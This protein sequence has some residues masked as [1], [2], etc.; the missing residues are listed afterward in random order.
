VAVITANEALLIE[1]LSTV[2]S[3]SM[4]IATPVVT[5][6]GEQPAILPSILL[7]THTGGF[8]QPASV[9][10]ETAIPEFR[11]HWQ[12]ADVRFKNVLI[13]YLGNNQKVYHEVNNLLKADQPNLV[14]LDPAFA[15]HGK[16]YTGMTAVVVE[17]YLQLCKHVQVFLPNFTEACLILNRKVPEHVTKSELAIILAELSKKTGLSKVAITGIERDNQIG[18]VFMSDQQ[19]KYVS[20]QKVSGDYF[21]TGDLFSSLVFEFLLNQESF[22]TALTLANQW[23][24]EAVADTIKQISR[25][26]RMGVRLQ[27]VFS[28]I[29]A[30]KGS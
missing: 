19:V 24:S 21:G 20:S 11:H 13:G 12:T 16:L 28:K 4:S 6:F 29:L 25:D 5:V 1:D 22:E 7:S 27:T 8:G 17:N 23:T 14:V 3:V 18:T 26:P 9:S 2:G 15:D 30:Y 10:M